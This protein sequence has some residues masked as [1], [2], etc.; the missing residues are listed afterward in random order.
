MNMNRMTMTWSGFSGAPGY[1]NMYFSAATAPTST[2]LNETAAKV[3]AYFYAWRSFLP[4]AVTVNFP[5]EMEEFSTTNGELITSRAVTP[6]ATVTGIGGSAVFSSAVGACV[7]W[8]TDT[9]VSGRKLR[10]R[11]FMV[12][13]QSLPSFDTDGSLN[14]SS[15][16]TMLSAAAALVADTTGLP[17]FIW[18]RP[19]PGGTDG[20]A[21]AV[22]ATT[23]NDKTAILRSRRD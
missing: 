15:R 11:T 13:L 12:P 3:R 7:N 22:T 23:I 21:G 9:V 6:G 14:P 4:N 5:S 8:K 1:T 20:A 17:F 18:H 10:G 19:S 2:Q 16:L